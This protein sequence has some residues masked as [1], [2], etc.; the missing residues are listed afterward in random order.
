M[1]AHRSTDKERST[2]SR[3]RA[4]ESPSHNR[5]K[6]VQRARLTGTSTRGRQGELRWRS[7]QAQPATSREQSTRKSTMH[8]RKFRTKRAPALE[9]SQRFANRVVFERSRENDW[10]ALTHARQDAAP[11]VG[12]LREKRLHK[13]SR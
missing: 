2:K 12:P 1:D 9:A 4:V 10:P 5:T 6:A 11:T 7:R 3:S 8:W 13:Q